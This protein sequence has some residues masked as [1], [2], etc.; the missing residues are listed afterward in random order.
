MAT[1]SPGRVVGDFARR[2]RVHERLTSRVAAEFL[3]LVGR[4]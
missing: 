3:V 2:L 1:L 4:R